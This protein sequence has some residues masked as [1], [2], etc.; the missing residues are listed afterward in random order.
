MIRLAKESGLQNEN[1]VQ[2]ENVHDKYELK[3]K[4]ASELTTLSFMT[5]SIKQ[6]VHFITNLY[7][8]EVWFIAH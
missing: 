6:E 7:S 1:G 8:N 3:N 5:F 4:T 2:N